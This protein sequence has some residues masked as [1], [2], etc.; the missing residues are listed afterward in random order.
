MVLRMTQELACSIL[1]EVEFIIALQ[2]VRKWIQVTFKRKTF[3]LHLN[4]NYFVFLCQILQIR[5][6]LLC[7]NAMHYLNAVFIVN[8]VQSISDLNAETD[9]KNPQNFILILNVKLSLQMQQIL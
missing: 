3:V 6:K 7:L 2:K 8:K 4:A 1:N 9:A 5:V